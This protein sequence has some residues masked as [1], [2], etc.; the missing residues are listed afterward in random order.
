MRKETGIR[1]TEGPSGGLAT[2]GE[3]LKHLEKVL[4]AELETWLLWAQALGS[5]K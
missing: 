2:L 5:A 1:E 4:P 3:S